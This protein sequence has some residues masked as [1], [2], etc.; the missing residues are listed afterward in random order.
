MNEC[1]NPGA[2]GANEQCKNVKAGFICVCRPG[3]RKG[4]GG[5]CADI[6]EC[7]SRKQNPC[8][9][10]RFCLNTEGSYK[11]VSCE[12]GEKMVDGKCVDIDECSYKNGRCTGGC[13]NTN[14]SYHCTCEK[15]YSEL[16][17]FFCLLKIV[18][19]FQTPPPNRMELE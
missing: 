7:L 8:S 12:K 19:I 3:Y 18:Q 10:G 2:C 15:G 5:I 9:R 13:V 14:G 1:Q 4:P 6:N 16:S 11:C 17:L